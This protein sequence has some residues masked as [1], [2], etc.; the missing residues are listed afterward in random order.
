MRLLGPLNWWAPR[1]LAG[2]HSRHR[3]GQPMT[4]LASLAAWRY[5]RHL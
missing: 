3:A 5:G 4:V 2:L 1:P